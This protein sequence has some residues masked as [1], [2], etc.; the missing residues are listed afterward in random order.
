MA[1]AMDTATE[2]KI[3]EAL[4]KLIK[5]KTTIMIAHRLSTLRD[6]DQLVV[7]EH[8]KVA[9][10]GTHAELLAKENGVYKK[11]FDLQLEALKNAGISE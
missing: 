5:G 7:I 2:R 9:E 6:A 11:L 3:Q 8:G 10:S 4:T 1:S